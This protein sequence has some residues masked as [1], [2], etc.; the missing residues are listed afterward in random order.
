MNTTT[1]I[2]AMPIS[3]TRSSTGWAGNRGSRCAKRAVL[4]RQLSRCFLLSDDDRSRIESCKDPDAL[5]AAFDEI[6]VCSRTFLR[7]WRGWRRKTLTC[8]GTMRVNYRSLKPI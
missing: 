8:T 3:W 2:S 6:V 7:G 4:T 5:D 1:P